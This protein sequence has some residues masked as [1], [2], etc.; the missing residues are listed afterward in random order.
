MLSDYISGWQIE[1]AT[2][3]DLLYRCSTLSG[4]M[5]EYIK[6]CVR[7]PLGK[8]IVQ[9]ER[10]NAWLGSPCDPAVREA[11]MGFW[12]ACFYN[13]A[14]F[15]ITSQSVPTPR[16]PESCLVDCNFL[17]LKYPFFTIFHDKIENHK[18]WLLNQ[19][20]SS[21]V[22]DQN[23]RMAAVCEQLTEVINHVPELQ[24]EYYLQDNFQDYVS[25]LYNTFSR[26]LC[27]SLGC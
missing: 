25:D 10:A 8:I 16:G 22:D 7:E 20:N 26:S 3:N 17:D 5:V 2:N 19:G 13:P 4:A 9:L 1:V 6:Q 12:Q 15:D 11:T 24:Y 14:V 27:S 23:E 18:D 21:N